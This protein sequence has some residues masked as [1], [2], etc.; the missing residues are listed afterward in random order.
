MHIQWLREM[1]HPPSQNT[2]GV[3]NQTTLFILYCISCRLVT[4]LK[5]T[6]APQQVSDILVLF[7]SNSLTLATRYLFPRFV[8][9]MHTSLMSYIVQIIFIT[10]GLG[11]VTT[12]F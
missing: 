11:P 6:D 5:V 8:L 9:E 10:K 3:C 2:V 7:V 1:V 4:F 12:A